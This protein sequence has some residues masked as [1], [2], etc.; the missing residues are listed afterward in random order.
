MTT[1]APHSN[2][3]L[4]VTLPQPTAHYYID[5]E[6]SDEHL[7]ECGGDSASVHQTLFNKDESC[8]QYTDNRQVLHAVTDKLHSNTGTGLRSGIWSTPALLLVFGDATMGGPMDSEAIIQ[9]MSEVYEPFV[10]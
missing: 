1:A 2:I 8:H 5:S 4:K 6:Q 7:F 3:D 10:F 9:H